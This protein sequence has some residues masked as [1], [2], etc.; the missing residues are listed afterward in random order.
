MQ[1]TPL[2]PNVL[3][4]QNSL[5]MTRLQLQTL[6]TEQD[7]KIRADLV[8]KQLLEISNAIL[9]SAKQGK[10]T[11]SSMLSVPIALVLTIKDDIIK[12]LKINFPD[13]SVT[14]DN[15]KNTIVVDWTVPSSA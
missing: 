2:M 6:K 7:A 15:L 14:F 8:K 9:L 13:S 4:A 5:P 3:N 11:Y 10:T 12:G 1:N